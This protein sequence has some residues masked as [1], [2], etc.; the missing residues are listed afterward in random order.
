MMGKAYE[1]K[2]EGSVVQMCGGVK[3]PLYHFVDS[4]D[5]EYETVLELGISIH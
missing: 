1:C 2:C 4:S 3:L 5:D